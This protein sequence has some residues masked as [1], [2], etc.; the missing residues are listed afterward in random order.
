SS[1]SADF[2]ASPVSTRTSFSYASIA[3]LKSR[4]FAAI[5]ARRRNAGRLSG[6]ASSQLAS[7]RWAFAGSPYR[8]RSSADK[9][10]HRSH[11]EVSF[12]QARPERRVR[13]RLEGAFERVGRLREGPACHIEVDQLVS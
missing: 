6:F 4:S 13:C 8:T 3:T 10:A 1:S 5:L 7:V 9:R 2:R 12:R 11:V